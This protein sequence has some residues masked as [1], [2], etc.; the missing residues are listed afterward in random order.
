MTVNLCRTLERAADQF[1][2][3]IAVADS[4]ERFTYRELERRVAAFD[5]GLRGLGVED[6]DVVAI[7]MLN[8]H[9]H[10]ELWFALPRGGFVINDL[11]IRLAPAELEFIL[12]DSGAVA[13]VVD[14]AFADAGSTLAAAC[15]SA[16]LL[17]HAGAGPAP[18]GAIAYE[19]VI[20]AGAEAIEPARSL[21][22]T[23]LAGIFYTGGTTGRPKGAMLSHANVEVN[24]KHV[25]ISWGYESDD[26]Y[27]HAAPMFHLADGASTY[28]V[29]A[30][31]GRHV[32]IPA[33][34]P[35]LTVATIESEGVTRALLVPTMINLVVNHPGT[36]DRDL[37]SVRRITYGAS[38]M[39]A[40]LLRR[41]MSTIPCEW[42]QAYGM[43]EAAPLVATLPASD[44]ERGARGEE[45]YATRLRSAGV[46][47]FGVEVSVRRADGSKAD[48]DEPGEIWARGPNMMSGYW[49]RPEETAAAFAPMAGTAPATWPLA[50]ADGYLYIVDR[51]KD[52]I[53]SGG[54]NI[55]SSE[56][57]N[58]LYDHPAILEAAVFGV[59]DE[60]WGERVHA[61]IVLHPGSQAG[62]ADLIE[63]CRP[64]IAGYKLPRSIEFHEQMLP[65]SGAGKILKRDL[66][67]PHWR[68]LER[69]VS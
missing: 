39:P 62:E 35:E 7:M 57:E 16:R 40:E 52:M 12:A 31:G 51:A 1:G 44:H 64:R 13:L 63:H 43:T 30:V 5:C 14:D 9:E 41:A 23:A 42:V 36:A 54:E 47:V 61:A 59:P 8:S 26:R 3:S 37:S 45:P 18:E 29:T 28:A 2:D 33:F 15:D 25:L 32:L 68:G 60:Q 24:A 50:D 48:L 46:P 27:L 49:N 4:G 11:N 21:A 55:Y 6:G 19:A 67:E 58:A 56:V 17:I 20:A 10:L 34:D 53:I 69:Q 66:R 38:P 22:P 65:K